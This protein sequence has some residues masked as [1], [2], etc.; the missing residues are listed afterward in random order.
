ML[1]KTY[2]TRKK[3]PDRGGRGLYQEKGLL[4]RFSS[5]KAFSH[6]GLCVGHLKTRSPKGCIT[7]GARGDYLSRSQVG[8]WVPEEVTDKSLSPFAASAP[9]RDAPLLEG[10]GRA[11]RQGAKLAEV[12]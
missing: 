6:F 1:Q 3:P 12:D 10:R 2:Q 11:S 8:A 7:L 4:Y 5:R 9:W